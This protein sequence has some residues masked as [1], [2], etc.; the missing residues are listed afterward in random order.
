MEGGKMKKR[1]KLLTYLLVV[2][3]LGSL[4]IGCS[5]NKGDTVKGQEEKSN[6]IIENGSSITVNKDNDETKPKD[7]EDKSKEDTKEE[8]KDKENIQVS[9]N[10]KTIQEQKEAVTI[11]IKYPVITGHP[12]KTIESNLNRIFEEKVLELKDI[13]EKGAEAA[14]DYSKENDGEFQKYMAQSSYKERYNKNGILSLTIS[15]FE[16]M[17]GSEG[18]RST[19]AYNID[20][21]S[22]KV[23]ELYEIFSEECDFKKIIDEAVLNTIKEN[24]EQYFQGIIDNYQGISDDQPFYIEEGNLVVYFA[25]YQL[26][27]ISTGEPEFKVPLSNFIFKEGLEIN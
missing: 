7:K 15:T 25:V 21:P 3:V 18:I 27:P 13:I 24:E 2:M 22:G 6:N 14:F 1:S 26:G 17:G 12:D 10:E 23:Y 4:L 19:T 8:T 5:S 16:F 11:D 9:I 20:L